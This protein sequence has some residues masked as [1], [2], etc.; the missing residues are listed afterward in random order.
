MKKLVT[1]LIIVLPLVF[2]IAVF[3]VT[4]IAKISTDIPATGINITN[5]G[6]NGVFAFD[7]ADYTSPMFESDLGVEVLPYV[8]KKSRIRSDRHGRGNGR[9]DGHRVP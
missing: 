2:L 7:I 5:K 4:N 3:A 9:G 8:A 1:A 6:D